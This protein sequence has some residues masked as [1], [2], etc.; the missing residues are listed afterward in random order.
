VGPDFKRPDAPAQAGYA[1]AGEDALVARRAEMG[2]KLQDD[3]WKLFSSPSLD[4]A[5]AKAI[6]GSKTLAAARET[7]A[8][9]QETVNAE[10]GGFLPEV[11][12]SGLAG[13]QKYGVALFGP[14]DFAVPPFTY[15]E[16]GPSASW[17]PDIFGG[18]RRSVERQEA[19]AEYQAH[20]L[21]AAY[22]S[23]TGNVAAQALELAAARAEMDATQK[24][25]G[26]DEKTLKLVKAAFD[27]GAGTKVEILSAQSQLDGDRALLPALR[28]RIS[29]AGH[30]L[31]VLSGKAPVDAAAPAFKLADFKMPEKL[32]V[33]LPS[34]MARARPDIL[35][36]EAQLHAASA[37]VGVATANLYP[38][39]N[40]TASLTQEALVPADLFKA[41][42]AA[43]ALA[44][45]I[46][47]PV[48][49]GGTLRAEKRAAEHA[50]QAALAQY[51][52]TVL[53]AFGQVAD[54]LTAIAHDDEALK[55]QKQAVETA[56]ASLSLARKSYQA[57]N[58]GLL[59]IQDAT[60]QLA[61]AQVGLARAQSQRLMD[62][63]RLFVALG[64]SP[65]RRVGS[66]DGAPAKG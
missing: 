33:S 21:A 39:I 28:Q 50:Y 31:A 34:E 2:R 63:A 22:V 17:T 59:Q 11:N 35:A 64:G 36:A 32:T 58:T 27:A 48:F 51:Q 3:W 52:E 45:G 16:A 23:L 57:G 37:A 30:A 44:G 55:A 47:A 14:S 20:E 46:T 62:A 13:R 12:V 41:S 5:I 42:S 1:A 53:H 25:I 7:L 26:E 49:N 4:D 8:Q 66:D 6:D 65:V 43:W 10:R 54:A 24:I 15:Y 29:A 60:R 9:A 18:Q 38:K 61:Q 19:L 40:L 56:S